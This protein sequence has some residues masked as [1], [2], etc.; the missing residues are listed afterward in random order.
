MTLSASEFADGWG[1]KDTLVRFKGLAE[2]L[3]P[4]SRE[5]LEQAGLPRHAAPYLS[6]GPEDDRQL[7]FLA[8]LG[9]DFERFHPIGSNGAGD[10][11]GLEIETGKLYEFDVESEL[12]DGHLVNSTPMQLAASL[13]VAR[14]LVAETQ[15]RNGPDAY[16][17]GNIPQDALAASLEKLAS[18]DAAAMEPGGFWVSAFA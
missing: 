10:P 14:D 16:L 7:A 1:A 12:L 8:D 17:D 18:I 9:F 6:F 13:L 11:I 15:R 4:E 3:P 2:G 5:F